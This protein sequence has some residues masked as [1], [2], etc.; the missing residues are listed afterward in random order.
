MRRDAP[1]GSALPTFLTNSTNYN[2]SIPLHNQ[3]ISWA[4]LPDTS[5]DGFAVL[6]DDV[7]KYVGPALNYSLSWL[8]DGLPH[9]F[10]LAVRDLLPLLILVTELFF[11]QLTSGGTAGDFTKAGTI[12]PNGT[13]SD[14]LAGPS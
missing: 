12:W 8:E 10:R 9:F 1:L 3:T 14:P 13:W 6:I 2:G 7:E 4:S 5:W 11:F